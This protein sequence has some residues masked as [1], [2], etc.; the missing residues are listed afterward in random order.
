MLGQKVA[1]E[2]IVAVAEEGS[3][4]TVAALSHVVRMTGDHDAGETGHAASSLW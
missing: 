1:V 3:R 2:R 4:A